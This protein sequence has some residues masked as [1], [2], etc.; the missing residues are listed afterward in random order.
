MTKDKP[1]R[2][3]K[4]V[5]THPSTGRFT[6]RVLNN[7]EEKQINLSVTLLEKFIKSRLNW[8]SKDP[9]IEVEDI[10]DDQG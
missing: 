9:S 4:L 2:S 10:E 6:A 1:T 3:V 8:G 5:V 7:A